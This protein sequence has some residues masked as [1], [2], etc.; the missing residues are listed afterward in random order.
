MYIWYELKIQ[1][2]LKKILK[3]L[4]VVLVIIQFYRPQKNISTEVAATDF[5]VVAKADDT[6]ASIIKNSCYDCHSNNTQ[7]PWYA[8][9]APLS[10]WIAYHVDEAKEEL[11]F[12]EWSTFSEKRKNKK[13]KEIVEELEER[14]MPLKTYLPMH[15]EAKLSD[16]QIVLLT[17][18]IKSLN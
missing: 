2:M 3:I 10:W 1:R 4:I 13:L 14:E 16:K 8:E 15:P 17:T 18:W 12:S 6:I 9:V 5:L 7:Y 11:N